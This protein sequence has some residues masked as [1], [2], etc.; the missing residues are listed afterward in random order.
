MHTIPSLP[1][2]LAIIRRS[3]EIVS[4]NDGWKRFG[5]HNGLERPASDW[6]RITLIIANLQ[7]ARRRN[8]LSISER[9]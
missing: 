3:G 6:V 4:V 7:T 1:V 9:C 8:H 2:N 5:Q